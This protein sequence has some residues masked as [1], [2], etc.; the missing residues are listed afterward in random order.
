VPPTKPAQAAS[1]VL[2]L[3]LL[4]AADRLGWQANF[5]I[6]QEGKCLHDCRWDRLLSKRLDHH[7]FQHLEA[8]ALGP[9]TRGRGGAG[10]GLHG[11]IQHHAG[12]LLA[13]S[14]MRH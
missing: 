3:D 13:P 2:M 7:H 5:E 14:N 1:K 12:E 9:Y 11:R 8:V 4:L 6:V 10:C